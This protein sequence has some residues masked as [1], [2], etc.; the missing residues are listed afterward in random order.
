MCSSQIIILYI[1]HFFSDT[2]LNKKFLVVVGVLLLT[3]TLPLS[4]LSYFATCLTSK[5]DYDFK[6]LFIMTTTTTTTTTTATTTAT[7]TTTARATA[8]TTTMMMVPTTL[9]PTITTRTTTKQVW[10]CSEKDMKRSRNMIQKQTKNT[11]KSSPNLSKHGLKT[12]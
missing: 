2:Y 8:T 5:S 3:F 12:K 10:N 6:N 11:S 4:Y 1:Q 7:T 9:K